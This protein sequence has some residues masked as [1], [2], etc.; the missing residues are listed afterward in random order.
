MSVEYQWAT[1]VNR[2]WLISLCPVLSSPLSSLLSPLSSLLSPLSSL[3]SP[4][5]SLLSPLS[6][7]LSPLSS[8]LSPLSSLLLSPPL[9]SS[10]LLSLSSLSL[11]LL[12]KKTGA[13][14]GGF[15]SQGPLAAK[16]REQ[17][18]TSN[19]CLHTKVLDG[20]LL[21][22]HVEGRREG[23]SLGN[24]QFQGN[25]VFFASLCRGG[26]GTPR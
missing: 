3:L 19:R 22:Q 21:R 17:S 11:R 1:P 9:S 16:Q 14:A 18:T 7:L 23:S 12:D 20:W 25:R 4:L 8:L 15:K 13:K 26:H 5:S 2:L 24:N 6:S 10:L